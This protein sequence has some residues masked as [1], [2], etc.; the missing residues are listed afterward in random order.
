[1][2]SPRIV[3]VTNRVPKTYYGEDRILLFLLKFLLEKGKTVILCIKARKICIEFR[4]DE[5]NKEMKVLRKDVGTLIRELRESIELV[6]FHHDV[7]LFKSAIELASHTWKLPM[8]ALIFFIDT[9]DPYT[10]LRSIVGWFTC[11]LRFSYIVFSRYIFNS[12]S[13]RWLIRRVKYLPLL[14]LMIYK[15][16]RC[17]SMRKTLAGSIRVCYIGAIDSERLNPRVIAKLLRDLHTALGMNIELKVVARPDQN[18]EEV[19]VKM[20]PWL[21]LAVTKKF[22]TDEEKCNLLNQCHV[23]VFTA[24]R[25][26]FVVPPMFVIEALQHRCLVYAPYLGDILQRENLRNIFT[27]STKLIDLLRNTL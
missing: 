15:P 2:K 18:V 25:M 11:Q 17:V 8:V 19:S 9:Y 7:S 26:R 27:D 24:K 21:K 23:A 10:L 12:L 13:K 22:L 16:C 4:Q 6:M 14:K 3:I 5:L 20:R 1:M